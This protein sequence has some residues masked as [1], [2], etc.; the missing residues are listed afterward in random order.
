MLSSGA[1]PRVLQPGIVWDEAAEA[2][3]VAAYRNLIASGLPAGDADREA[4]WLVEADICR[5]FYRRNV[6]RALSCRTNGEKRALYQG[7]VKEF[8]KQR[9]ERLA[10]FVKN[11]K[12]R[13]AALK[14]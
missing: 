10:G 11:E 12:A 2:A 3:W 7:W 6:E 14:W 13:E 9:A 8:G 5:K 1:V 4:R